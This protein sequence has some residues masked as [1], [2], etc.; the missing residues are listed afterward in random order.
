M[1]TDKKWQVHPSFV[2][3]VKQLNPDEAKYLKSIPP[4][5]VVIHP[6]I[7]VGFSFGNNGGHPI[8]SNLN[9]PPQL[10]LNN[11]NNNN[12]DCGL[13]HQSISTCI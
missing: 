2:D 8:I 5:T 12:N 7:D 4:M 10:N 1:N 9:N 11:S 6:L 13:F 3:I